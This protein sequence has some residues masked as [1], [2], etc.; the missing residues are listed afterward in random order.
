MIGLMLAAAGTASALLLGEWL[1]QKRILKGEYARKFV[2]ITVATFAAFW[3]LLVT[4]PQIVF[5]NFVFI[6]ALIVIK[7][8]GLFKSIQSAKRASYGEIWYAIGISLCAILFQDNV[9]YA[10]AVLHMA[11]A[12]GFAAI[13]GTK[14]EHKAIH[15]SFRSSRKSCYGTLTFIVISFALNLS[16]WVFSSNNSLESIGICMSPIIYSALA[17][18]LLALIEV[19]SPRGSDNVIVPLGAG[20]ILAAPIA[21]A[22]AYVIT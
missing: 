13:I 22:S 15:F 8:L 1:W 18:V 11:L 2:H 4:R 5:L 21:L 16:Y 9:I 20:F 14:L 17:A 3:P 12:D 7:K 10:V 19:I 6:C